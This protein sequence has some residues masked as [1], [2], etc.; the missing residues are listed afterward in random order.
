M[1]T[2]YTIKEIIVNTETLIGFSIKDSAV[3]SPVVEKI[4]L[5]A[6]RPSDS[7]KDFSVPMS[8]S[9]DNKTYQANISIDEKGLHLNSLGL[10]NITLAHKD[11]KSV[12][13]NKLVKTSNTLI[14]VILIIIVALLAYL[15]V[16]EEWQF[17]ITTAPLLLGCL[18][19]MPYTG[20]EFTE[21]ETKICCLI[22]N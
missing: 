10:K 19:L 11:I 12:A 14:A 6:Y 2:A 8:L 5:F 7:K 4:T 1:I 18:L 20:K 17:V 22:Q 16:L 15:V 3:K 21:L 9:D 13:P